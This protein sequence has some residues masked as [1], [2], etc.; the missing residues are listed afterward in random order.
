MYVCIC[1]AVTEDDLHAEIADGA[2]TEDD[3][4][5]RCGAG[6]GCGSCSQRI[7]AALTRSA[8]ACLPG[9]RMSLAV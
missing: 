1:Y 6:T 4:A 7:C 3:V 5:A 9:G 8:P 2:R